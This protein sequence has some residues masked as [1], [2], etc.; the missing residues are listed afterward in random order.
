M[1]TSSNK[2]PVLILTGS[3]GVGKSSVADAVSE[4]LGERSIARAVIEMDY[5]RYAYPRPRDDPFHTA[6]GV[7][8][9]GVVW[10]NYKAANISRLVIPH[11]VVSRK[12][13]EDIE[14]AIPGSEVLVIRLRARVETL[15]ERL[16]EREKGNSLTWNL[17][18]AIELSEQLEESK[19]EDFVMDTDEKP[20]A[21]IA[22]EILAKWL[23]AS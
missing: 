17:N 14:T 6:L 8:N 18:R 13:V 2:V 1:K 9:L 19:I 7:K 16:K 23:P 12:E 4:L 22:Q 21:S 3:V 15:H 10:K 20:V 11:V 5:L